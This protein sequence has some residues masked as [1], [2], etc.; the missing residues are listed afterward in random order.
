MLNMCRSLNLAS[1]ACK[2][3][4]DLPAYSLLLTPAFHFALGNSRILGQSEH[5]LQEMV[6]DNVFDQVHLV[7]KREVVGIKLWYRSVR[8]HSDFT[9]QFATW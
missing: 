4:T 8:G 7:K 3:A 9:P 5:A 6:P 2:A 1:R